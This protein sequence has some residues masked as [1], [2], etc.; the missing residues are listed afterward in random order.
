MGIGGVESLK[1]CLLDWSRIVVPECVV[2][3]PAGCG[4]EDVLTLLVESLA[5]AGRLE[6]ELVPMIVD[7]L[8]QR[9]RIGTTGLGRGLGLPHLRSRHVT[10][11]LG[12][13]GIA[14][15]GVEFHSLD[16]QPTRLIILIVS[17][18]TERQ[19]HGE[20]MGRLATLLTDKTWQYSVQI[21]RSP[22]ALF[23]FLG[24]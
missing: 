19:T 20:I 6:E 11:F 13:V 17:P 12:A 7:E 2:T 3:V 10:D 15:S 16:G 8:L 5:R 14:P 9:E 21:P 1:R 18:F 4:K 22:E 23:R 24:F